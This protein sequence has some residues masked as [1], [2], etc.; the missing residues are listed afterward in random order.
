MN[1]PDTKIESVLDTYLDFFSGGVPPLPFFEMRLDDLLEVAGKSPI[2]DGLDFACELCV[3]GLAAYFEAFC[4]DQFSA[5]IN[6]APQTLSAFADARECRIPIKSLLHALPDISR[7]LGFVIAEE[8]D[9]G[10]A[11]LIN[12]LFN[13]L[14]KIT[15]FSKAEMASYSE[16]LND[17]NLLVHHGGVYTIKY[18]AQKFQPGDIKNNAHFNSLTVGKKDVEKWGNFL[19][20]LARKI[21]KASQKGLLTFA[22]T[23]QIQFDIETKKGVDSLG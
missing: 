4:K 8:Y 9:F 10:S 1:V 23:H 11:K 19:F 21:A 12:G 18:A 6:I 3:I 22:E 17:R 13:D 5:I 15:P 16:F 7:R 20:D 2:D 14:L